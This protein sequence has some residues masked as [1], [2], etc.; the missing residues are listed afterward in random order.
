[1]GTRAVLADFAEEKGEAD[2][3]EMLRTGCV[4]VSSVGGW[5]FA[6]RARALAWGD[7]EAKRLWGSVGYSQR[8]GSVLAWRSSQNA[9]ESGWFEIILT[10]IKGL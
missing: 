1:M 3:A 7:A 5:A 9:W 8:S 10:E 6:S 2:L 4:W